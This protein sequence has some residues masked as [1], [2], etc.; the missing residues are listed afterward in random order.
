MVE[1]SRVKQTWAG[2]S[3]ISSTRGYDN[4]SME[5]ILKECKEY[6]KKKY[7]KFFNLE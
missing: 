4:L 6:V 1:V 3:V 7:D 5:Y 2:C